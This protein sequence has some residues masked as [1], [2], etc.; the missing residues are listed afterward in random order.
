M[1]KA[2]RRG[3]PNSFIVGDMP[4][5]SYQVSDAEAVM[6]AGRYI[7]EAGCDA[8][9]LEE[10]VSCKSRIKAIVDAGIAVF[11]HIGMTPQA[12]GIQGVLAQGRTVPEAKGVIEDAYAVQEAGAHFLL[13]EA[14]PPEVSHY[15]TTQ[16]DIPVF[17]I[18]GGWAVDGQLLIIADLVGE[19]QAFTPKFVKKYCNV[20][21]A[22]TTALTS[23]VADVKAKKFPL[24]EHCYHCKKDEMGPVT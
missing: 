22:C 5:M 8:I 18:G 21:E 24:D 13:M 7:K 15:V 20:A 9:K 3:A 17:G 10:G 2:A 11:G 12:S 23:Y 4:F 6:N 1:C 16:L 19:F 14:V